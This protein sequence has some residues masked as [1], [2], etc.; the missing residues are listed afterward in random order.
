MR[1]EYGYL[2]VFLA[3]L[4]SMLLFLE[5]ISEFITIVKEI[6]HLFRERVKIVENRH[7]LV[8]EIPHREFDRSRRD[9]LKRME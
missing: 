1:G 2:P 9:L 4:V 8:P 6:I 3:G 7:Q 5:K